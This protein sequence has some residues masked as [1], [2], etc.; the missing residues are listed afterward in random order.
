MIDDDEDDDRLTREEIHER[1]GW[2]PG[3]RDQVE[4]EQAERRRQIERDEM[5]QWCEQ[6]N[7]GS[8]VTKSAPV[9][10][11]RVAAAASVDWD[12]WRKFIIATV[13]K[14]F[15]DDKMLEKVVKAVRE[16]VEEGDISV[17]TATKEAREKALE[18]LRAEISQL[19]VEVA[20]LRGAAAVQ[21]ANSNPAMSVADERRRAGALVRARAEIAALRAG[22]KCEGAPQDFD[23]DRLRDWRH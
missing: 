18:P 14:K 7:I 4:H 21:R 10:Q 15:I 16:Y 17:C 2:Q 12:A 23:I 9:T 5:L 1:Y 6:R 13:D 19:R 11:P 20:E 22:V 8:V 3:E